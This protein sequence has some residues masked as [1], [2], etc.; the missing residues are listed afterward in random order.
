MRKVWLWRVVEEV[1]DGEC[2][3]DDGSRGGQGKQTKEQQRRKEKGKGKGKGN[4]QK[5]SNESVPGSSLAITTNDKLQLVFSR[6]F[7]TIERRAKHVLKDAYKE[8]PDAADVLKS[9]CTCDTP[10]MSGEKESDWYD[11][12]TTQCLTP[13]QPPLYTAGKLWPVVAIQKN[14]C[15]ACFLPLVA[16]ASP[17]F[18]DP[19]S[20][21]ETPSIS[22]GLVL[23]EEM[24]NASSKLLQHENVATTYTQLD[25]F[26]SL[27]CPMGTYSGVTY[28]QLAKMV[29]GK[30]ETAQ[31]KPSPA[32]RVGRIDSEAMAFT[33]S[34]K[35]TVSQHRPD[36]SLFEDLVVSGDV[37]A[38]LYLEDSPE[39]S[40][41]VVS[42]CD[43]TKCRVNTCV[44]HNQRGTSANERRLTLVPPLEEF[45]LLQYK[46][47]VGVSPLEPPLL[48]NY[49]FQSSSD[50]SRASFTFNID[51]SE[52]CGFSTFTAIDVSF[53]FF[54]RGVIKSFS[55]KTKPVGHVCACM[56]MSVRFPFSLLLYLFQ[57]VFFH[58]YSF[59]RCVLTVSVRMYLCGVL[60][61]DASPRSC[62]NVFLS[63]TRRHRQ[64][65]LTLWRTRSVMESQHTQI[66][67]GR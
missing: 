24:L 37:S 63:S 13:H 49:H 32:W 22:S 59:R 53:P 16:F 67:R 52:K 42:T 39:V 3:R 45:S 5:P 33:V 34:E 17:S 30:L 61:E 18:E 38:K 44:N 58:S 29:A 31:T 26:L 41:T 4:N 36:D 19:N 40:L 1:V 64:H 35:I 56:R 43:L 12:S 51:K 14:G 10:S 57:C 48:A 20:I 27:T 6:G 2:D 15:V 21:I 25:T 46:T 28:S 54:N 55:V 7:P 66:L 23:L 62:W 60:V 8:I 50:Y 47:S 11:D 65:T 9:L